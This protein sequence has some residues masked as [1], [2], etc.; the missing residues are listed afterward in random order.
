V[1]EKVNELEKSISEVGS[2]LSILL[3]GHD[4]IKLQLTSIADTK[5][6]AQRLHDRVD[7]QD[8]EIKYVK[9]E[10]GKI[11]DAIHLKSTEHDVRCSTTTE[12]TEGKFNTRLW[13][14]LGL[15]FT[16]FVAFGYTSDARMDKVL[17]K[18]D[19]I[20]EK[21]TDVKT[22]VVVNGNNIKHNGEKVAKNALAIEKRHTIRDHK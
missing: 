5:S 4:M 6:L 13:V 10:I 1:Q 15:V 21:V 14:A 2:K 11:E 8:R 17:D 19:L 18:L 22:K 9:K 16:M 3:E 20:A 12:K 7:A